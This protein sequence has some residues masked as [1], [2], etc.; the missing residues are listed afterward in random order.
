MNPLLLD[1][2]DKIKESDLQISEMKSL[3]NIFMDLQKGMLTPKE[4][5]VLRYRIKR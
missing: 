4:A 5:T 2:K 1:L 3:L